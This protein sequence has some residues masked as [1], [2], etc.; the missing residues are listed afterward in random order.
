DL[1]REDH[2][3]N[4]HT[5]YSMSYPI[6]EHDSQ[7]G[8]TR[9]KSFFADDPKREILP[10][11][12][13]I[14][15]PL[16]VEKML[17]KK[18]RWLTLGG[19]Y[20]WTEKVYPGET[21]PAFPEDVASFIQGLFP[22]IKAEAAIVNFYSPGDVLS[23]HRDVSEECDVPLI[24]ISIGDDAL[25]LVGHADDEEGKIVRLRSGDAICM[26]G[27]SRFA[28]HAVPKIVPGTCPEW[29]RDWPGDDDARPEYKQWKGWMA[30]KRIN[31]NRAVTTNLVFSNMPG[32]TI[33]S[34]L[35][36]SSR[37][38]PTDYV[39]DVQDRGFSTEEAW[40]TTCR[41]KREDLR[42]R[43][44]EEWLLKEELPDEGTTRDFT[45]DFV[46]LTLT[47][48]EV[49]ITETT[50]SGI[51]QKTTTGAWS[52]REVAMLAILS[53]LIVRQAHL[54]LIQVN[55]LHE[56][57]FDAAIKDAEA[58]DEYLREHGK[59]MG[60]LH[61]LPVS[62]KDQFHV[63]GVDTSMGYVGWLGTFEGE[64]DDPRHL[65]FESQLVRDLR[66]LGAVLYC[67]T[68][69]PPTLM[70]PETV[71][72]IVGY[73]ANP[74]NRHLTAGGSSGGEGAL[75][76]LRG[77]AAGFGSDIGGSLRIPSAFNG[78]YGLRPSTGR[79]PY[80][81][82]AQPAVGRLSLPSV[83]GPMSTSAE[84][85]Q[86]LMEAALSRKPWLHDPTAVPLPWRSEVE[87]QVRG[88]I[89]RRN[90]KNL[91]FGVLWDDGVVHP[92]PP[93]QRALL[94]VTRI[95]EKLGHDSAIYSFDAGKDSN[96][97]IALSGE[98]ELRLLHSVL[99]KEGP[100]Y[101]ASKMVEMDRM[102]RE[103]QKE[104]L[105]Y[106][107]ASAS[108]TD[109][110]EPVDA[111]ISPVAPYASALPGR[112]DYVGY[113]IAINTLDFSAITFPVTQADEMV[114]TQQDE[115]DFVPLSDQD[116]GVYKNYDA[117]VYHGAFVGLQLVGRRYE[118]EKLITLAKYLSEQIELANQGPA[119]NSGITLEPRLN[120]LKSEAP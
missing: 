42:R 52:A 36:R 115:A 11:N 12:S 10:K 21:P 59:P 38:P 64:S 24:S 82:V 46:R 114:D 111:F 84:G 85:I 66:S 30:G 71:N 103:Y 55:C 20:D 106:W 41:K 51:L 47:D 29:L 113:T 79:L 15:Q 75:I 110:G 7:S 87:H 70:C 32:F 67:K 4:L 76:A 45:G 105:D 61:G 92:Q 107:N 108:F 31:L 68:S 27:P 26:S 53:L 28:W 60:P 101:K 77:S 97:Q 5:H 54:L 96:A 37:Q 40:E 9:S 33:K 16:S 14:H 78:I 35:R 18:L 116:E 1:V 99:H 91:A 49:E 104:Y 50:V 48:H 8:L 25:F 22:S 58:L 120:A 117:A 86:I 13:S 72:N 80:E 19:Q 56:I 94:L 17:N 98:P 44:P 102:K 88:K 69:C 81:G 109:S 23:V 73:T 112:Y 65:T 2:K 62:L 90:G 6:E 39:S 93:I 118:E 34:I 3:T 57:F 43:I 89:E 83:I 74:R 119:T 63:K 100:E 95:I